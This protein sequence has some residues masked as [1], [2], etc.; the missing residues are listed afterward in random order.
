ME[1]VTP[2]RV[3]RTIQLSESWLPSTHI[4]PGCGRDTMWFPM[5][6]MDGTHV[7]ITCGSVC[8]IKSVAASESYEEVIA[9]IREAT[10]WGKAQ[11]V[12]PAAASAEASEPEPPPPRTPKRVARQPS[13]AGS[14]RKRK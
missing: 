8:S 13:A 1:I 6:A 2:I 4:C 10:G 3:E 7:C 5:E 9:R 12:A 11:G 14:A